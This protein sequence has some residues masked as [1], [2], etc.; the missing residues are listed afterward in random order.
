MSVKS[1]QGCYTAYGTRI[2]AS[3]VRPM[4]K[5]IGKWEIQPPC[6]IV[7]SKNFNSKVCTR[8]YIGGDYQPC[9]FWF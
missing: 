4:Q 9:K 8:D 1:L 7:T 3:V 5:S 2:T 6:K